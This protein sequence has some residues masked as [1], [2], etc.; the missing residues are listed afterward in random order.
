MLVVTSLLGQ[1]EGLTDYKGL[2]RKRRVNGERSLSFLLIKKPRNEHA[3]PLVEEESIIEFNGDEYRIKNLEEKS[4][5][6]TVIK[7]ITAHHTFFDLID[8][9]VYDTISGT[10]TIQEVLSFIFANTPYTFD[11]VDAFN[12]AQFEDFGDDN[13][14]SLFQ[15]VLNTFGAE[16]TINGK[17]LTIKEQVGSKTD[18]QFRYKHN[19]KVLSK[20]VDTSNLST[21]IKGYGKQNEDGTYV[22]T[23][24][25]TSPNASIF[26]IRHAPP[27]RDERYTDYNSLLDRLQKEIKDVPDVSFSLDFVDLRAAGYPYE[28]PGEGDE[29]YVIHEPMGI[30]I[31]TRIMGIDEEFDENG[32]VIKCAVTLANFRPNATDI[33]A[34][35]GQVQKTVQNIV[36]ESGKV[37]YNVLDEAVK[38]VTEAL[39][40][41]QTELEFTN[42]IIAR[43]KTD[44]NRLVLYN[45]KGLG[46]SK[47]G[48][49]TFTEAI[50][51]DGF[52][53]TAGV[54]GKLSA[55]NI[56]VTGVIQAI[57]EEGS[58]TIDGKK[59]TTGSIGADKIKTDEL[60]VGINVQMDP[61]TYISWNQ[62]SN[63]PFIP[64]TASDIGALSVYSP[65]LTYIDQYGI[66]TG[67]IHASQITAG[68]ISADR[69]WGGRLTGVTIDVSTDAW[70]GRNLFVG[71]QYDGYTNYIRF[72]NNSYIYGSPNSITVDA[73][74]V[75]I[76]RPPA[77]IQVNG[78]Y[79]AINAPTYL[80]GTIFTSIETT[81]Q[82][83][84]DGTVDSGSGSYGY[85]RYKGNTDTYLRLG[86]S[87]AA[88]IVNGSLKATW[89]S[90]PRIRLEPSGDGILDG[91][92]FGANNP[93]SMQPFLM[94]YFMNLEVNGRREVYLDEKFLEFV[95]SYDV[96]LSFSTDVRMTE[97]HED[98]FV[99][100]GNGVISCMAVG[101]QRGKE[102]VCGYSIEEE[103]V[104][105]IDEEGQILTDFI[106]VGLIPKDREG[107]REIK[108][109][110]F[111]PKTR[112][113]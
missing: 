45:S 20:Y 16:F 58:T 11:V 7:N 29:V 88:I 32:K 62:I 54:I 98:H 104:D 59:I 91:K 95:S 18:F 33:L 61:N 77:Y 5:G 60:I 12:S 31:S 110:V 108:E 101:I 24:E 26:G 76:G 9:Y 89:S 111:K 109:S 35:F 66:Y 4:V 100:E 2:K 105:Y 13:V 69:I 52:V 3:F 30:D 78:S 46:I 102:N 70:V 44:P 22:V 73:T 51:A 63:K 34:E 53:L 64:Q 93:A 74:Y 75:Q 10:K 90:M 72:K 112:I 37:R 65:R 43:E 40:S 17:H 19:L 96:F 97:K 6:N 79:V 47:D 86:Y 38:R 28:V 8:E 113:V 50:T 67:T 55:N 57:N 107:V 39:Q 94:D 23:A 36:S 81:G 42:G 80:Y 85:F 25:Y 48:G 1:T 82:I 68:Y 41:A 56:D 21:Y 15:K 99:L 87:S 103:V 106:E 49:Q 83:R 27:V 92:E 84:A 71:D 14:L